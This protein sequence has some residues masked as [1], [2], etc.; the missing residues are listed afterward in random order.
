DEDQSIRIILLTDIRNLFDSR[1]DA[2]FP[3]KELI[4]GLVAIEE[5]PWLMWHR[6]KPISPAALAKLLAPFGIVPVNL[7]LPGEKVLKGYRG[8]HFEDAFARSLP[9]SPPAGR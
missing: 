5:R 2:K 7:K 3:T 4:D 8:E 1:Q 6:G 9:P